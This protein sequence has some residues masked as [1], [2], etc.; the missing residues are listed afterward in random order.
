MLVVGAASQREGRTRAE[1]A[2]SKSTFA[3]LVSTTGVASSTST[4][5]PL[6]RGSAVRWRMLSC[7]SPLGWFAA[8]SVAN[9]PS[10]WSYLDT[11]A[12]FGVAITVRS[13]ALASAAP[14]CARKKGLA[15]CVV[16]GSEIRVTVP[17]LRPRPGRR[18]QTPSG[19]ESACAMPLWRRTALAALFLRNA[20]PPTVRRGAWDEFRPLANVDVVGEHSSASRPLHPKE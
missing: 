11:T 14:R 19:G 15:A 10:R 7:F 9:L 8:A 3:G 16:R 5:K 6:R 12:S 20:L 2:N 4:T 18:A 13:M 17:Q 1:L